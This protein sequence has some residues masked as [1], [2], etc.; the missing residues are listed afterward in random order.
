MIIR[1][2]EL[3]NFLSHDHSL[4]NFDKGVTVI[5]G[6]NGAGKSSLIDAVKFALFGEK[7]G[8]Q[9][10]DLIRRGASDMEVGLDFEIGPDQYRISRVMGL[11][12]S[13]INKR[14]ATL[15]KNKSVLSTTVKSVDATVGGIL[16]IDR[17]AFMNSVFVEQG[18]IDTLISKTASER[19][20]T[21][22]RIL[23]L[24]LLGKYADDLGKLSRETDAR[25]Q[26]FSNVAQ[27]MEEIENSIREK[28][29]FIR[30]VGRGISAVS[31]ERKGISEKLSGLEKER[32]ELQS[33]IS[34]LK[35]VA[36]TVENRRQNLN[37]V[38]E[39]VKQRSEEIRTL[40]K[41]LEDL[42]QGIDQD[43]MGRSEDITEYFS[44]SEPLSTKRAILKDLEERIAKLEKMAEDIK[45][46]EQGYKAYSNLDSKLQELRQNRARIEEKG[47]KFGAAEKRIEEIRQEAGKKKANLEFVSSRLREM[48]GLQE[49]TRDS[50]LNLR[51][52][53]ES[54]RSQVSEKIQEIRALVG[55]YNTELKE[56]TEKR[57]K[58]PTSD[59]CP[60]CL[61]DLS[62]D[63]RKRIDQE[64][65][66]KEDSL[67]KS[68]SDLAA[69]KGKLDGKISGIAERLNALVTKDV[70]QALVDLQYAG[71]LE[72]EKSALERTLP[73]L[74]KDHD[75]LA[76]FNEEF[77]QTEGNMIK[78]RD[79]YNQYKSFEMTLSSS[80]L[81][82]LRTR[83]AHTI[84]EVRS[85]EGRLSELEGRIG[86]RPDPEI[87]ARI[88]EMREREK[89][90]VKLR[91]ERLSKRA[92]QDSD[93]DKADELRKEIGMLEGRL[94]GYSELEGK[95]R[96]ISGIYEETNRRLQD[97]IGRESSLRTS[98][99]SEEK[100]LVQLREGLEKLK[101]DMQ[102]MENIR[103]SMGTINKL[104]SCFDRDGIQ[105]AIR[106][107][108]AVYITNRVREYSSSFNLDFDDVS[109]NEDMSIVVSQNGNLESID[110]LSGGEKVA[111][112][113]ALR[114][115]LA[116]YVLDS[117]KTIVM[118]EPTT[119]LDEDRRN[120]LKDIIQYTFR[121]DETPVPQMVIVTHHK[122]LGSVA[123][124][125]FEI[126]KKSGVSLVT[127]G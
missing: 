113:I 103:K 62:E 15:T 96:E 121:G 46:L 116:T 61:Q 3:K 112:A 95:F 34:D 14:D 27:N 24:D 57:S 36:S 90:M 29:E 110:M 87:R 60:L 102:T 32:S 86:F 80:N 83:L 101:G 85:D 105:K 16:G 17:D 118:D 9:I 127:Q 49:I 117:I 93:V 106:K 11:G 77:A 43:L 38:Q 67:R 120:N 88:K 26:S 92:A 78:L 1:Q 51:S 124:N 18:E 55:R 35:S 71:Q 42:S 68:L 45:G 7:R 23:G 13:G 75:E 6:H 81:D 22:S 65:A 74:K 31:A 39:L 52:E 122:E 109:I 19:E 20:R 79:A 107:D 73:E 69:A 12:K 30:E 28:V 76:A 21:F 89:G 33:S 25:L 40:E 100:N 98:M 50:V 64:Y 97:I 111:L 37:Q 47:A 41:K 114:L 53:F 70:D 10:A 44:I 126:S 108:S 82:E 84:G 8:G 63:H 72:K 58:L 91:D 2:L 48:F 4:V 119:Y 104:R 115:S 54:D 56:V 94:T 59:R 5:Y 125:V 99:D 66:A 123:D